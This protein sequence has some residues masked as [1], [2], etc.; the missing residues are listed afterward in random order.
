M[1]CED[2]IA[3]MKLKFNYM[4]EEDES[5]LRY[6]LDA[7]KST[8]INFYCFTQFL[9]SFGPFDKSIL[10]VNLFYFIFFFCIRFTD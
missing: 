2:L 5:N 10:N 8:F 7:S 4:T 9:Q 1:K 3:Q 6:V